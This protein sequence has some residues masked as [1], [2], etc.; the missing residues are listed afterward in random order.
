VSAAGTEAPAATRRLVR[1]RNDRVIA[2]VA[3]GLGDYFGVDPVIFRLGF[4]AAAIAGGTGL[5]AYLAAW[6]LVPEA[7]AAGEPASASRRAPERPQAWIGVALLVVGAAMIFGEIGW[8]GPDVLWALALIGIGILLFRNDQ[9]KRAGRMATPPDLGSGA[10]AAEGTP[11]PEGDAGPAMGGATEAAA[12][13]GPSAPA[14]I[15]PPPGIAARPRPRRTRSMLGL[16]TTGSALVAMAVATLLSDRGSIDLAG[17]QILSIGLAVVGAGMLVGAWLGRARWLIVVGL[18]LVPFILA[19]NLVRVPLA[20]GSGERSFAPGST[21]EMRPRYELF[22]GRLMIDLTGLELDRPTRVRADVGA[23]RVEVKVARG[24]AT[25]VDA[26]V[27]IGAV[28][29]FG[30][31]QMGNDLSLMRSVGDRDAPVLQLDLSSTIG[32]VVVSRG[33][34]S[35]TA[36]IPQPTGK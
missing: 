3:G 28:D 32:D 25:T 9:E 26:D 10:T 2:G 15:W 36:P 29:L 7:P 35:T 18:L 4:V 20:A 21:S 5:I 11:S 6:L 24:V 14:A 30:Y 31:R 22:A 33:S 34:A 13:A 1:R 16:L 8:W 27:E 23:G 19:A 17:Y 12:A